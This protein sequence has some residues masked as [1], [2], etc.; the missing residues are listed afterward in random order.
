[1]TDFIVT[2]IPVGHPIN[3]PGADVI[4]NDAAVSVGDSITLEL[5]AEDITDYVSAGVLQEEAAE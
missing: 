2:G 1:M 5:E 3:P 4:L